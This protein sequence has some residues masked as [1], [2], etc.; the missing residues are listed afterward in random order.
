MTLDLYSWGFRR[1]LPVSDVMDMHTL[2][3]TLVETIRSILSV[4]VCARICLT[5]GVYCIPEAMFAQGQS[6]IKI[7]NS[8]TKA[9][10]KTASSM[11]KT[12][13]TGVQ[14]SPNAITQTY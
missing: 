14:L 8:V 9:K 1:T 11:T 7:T 3:S 2:L 6:T 5:A 4:Y 10:I 12:K 13:I